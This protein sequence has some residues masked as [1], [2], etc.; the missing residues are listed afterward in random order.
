MVIVF[1]KE[2]D[3]GCDNRREIM[4]AE[5]WQSDIAVLAGLLFLTIILIA[6]TK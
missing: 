5:N 1:G 2:F 6:I 3:C 4:G